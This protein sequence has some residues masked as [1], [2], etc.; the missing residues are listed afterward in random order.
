MLFS[1]LS[2]TLKILSRFD[3]TTKDI[4]S[5]EIPRKTTPN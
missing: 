3:T 5:A 1:L 4:S 2:I